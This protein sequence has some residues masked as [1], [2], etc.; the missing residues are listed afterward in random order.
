MI[1]GLLRD[2]IQ[3]YSLIVLAAV[4][5]SWVA[6]DSRHKFVLL[7]RSVT[8]PV[9]EKVRA[10]VPGMSGIDFSPMIVLLGLHFLQKL[11]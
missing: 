2:L 9:F 3:I 4:I 7:L 1:V 6:P 11:L 10:I 5:V 8:E